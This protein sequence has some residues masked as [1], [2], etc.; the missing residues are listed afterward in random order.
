MDEHVANTLANCIYQDE[1]IKE[2][3]AADSTMT[4]EQARALTRN[5]MMRFRN[6]DRD[7]RST[8]NSMIQEVLTQ[9]AKKK[10]KGRK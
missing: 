2:L 10:K 3:M 1:L 8:V 7:N 5:N 9:L 4:R 6:D